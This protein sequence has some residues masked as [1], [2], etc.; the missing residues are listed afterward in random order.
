MLKKIFAVVLSAMFIY[1]CS[2]QSQQDKV[3]TEF[4]KQPQ[5]SVGFYSLREISYDGCTYIVSGS[6]YSQMITHKGNCDNKFHR[7][8]W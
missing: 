2:E 5:V 8:L 3:R 4:N 6:G 1:G 7:K